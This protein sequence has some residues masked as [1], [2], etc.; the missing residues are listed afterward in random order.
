MG[1]GIT[2]WEGLVAEGAP[3]AG[4]AYFP[5][6]EKTETLIALAW[7][8]EEGSRRFYSGLAGSMT[9]PEGKALFTELTAAEERHKSSLLALYRGTVGSGTIESILPGGAAGDVME[10]GVLVSQAMEWT[11]GRDVADILDLSIAL[12]SNAYDLYIKM[13][14]TMKD[15]HAKRAFSALAE[16]EKRH[17]ARMTSLI[18]R[19]A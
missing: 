9:D 18:E 8:L 14:R 13:E 11:A 10:G 19:K 5:P 16:E 17:L 3:E 1:G 7:A 2:A 15:D 12:E 4:M 6:N